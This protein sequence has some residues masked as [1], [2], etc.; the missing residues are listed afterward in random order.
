MPTFIWSVR[1]F[2]FKIALDNL[3]ISML[4]KWLRAKRIQ[5]TYEK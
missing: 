4:K 5:I 2:G 1:Q 3:F